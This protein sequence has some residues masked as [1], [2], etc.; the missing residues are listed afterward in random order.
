MTLIQFAGL[1]AIIC[2]AF[3]ITSRNPVLSV[4]FLIGVFLSIALWLVLHGATYLGL[5]YIIIYVGAIAILFLFV[6]IMLNIKASDLI[7]T[8]LELSQN[9]P[10]GT[11]LILLFAFLLTPASGVIGHFIGSFQIQ[12]LGVQVTPEF[13]GGVG[14]NMSNSVGADLA[15]NNFM[16]IESIGIGLYTNLMVWLIG[17]S[18]ILMLAM[19]GPILLCMQGQEDEGYSSTTEL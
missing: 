10:L 1:A 4:L 8:G 14:E 19:V 15:L 3:V 9:L 16:Q 2:G 5:A 11:L 18:F 12:E 6:I 7:Y 17:V 13:V